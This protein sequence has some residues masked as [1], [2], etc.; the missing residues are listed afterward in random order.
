MKIETILV[1]SRPHQMCR[2]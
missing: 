2:K 1:S